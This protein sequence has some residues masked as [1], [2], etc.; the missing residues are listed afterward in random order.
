[1]FLLL[2]SLVLII[3][4]FKTV[5]N[6]MS[7]SLSKMLKTDVNYS[8][9]GYSYYVGSNYDCYGSVCTNIKNELEEK[10]DD[11]NFDANKVNNYFK[12]KGINNYYKYN[13]WKKNT[14]LFIKKYRTMTRKISS[15]SVN[16][17]LLTYKQT[18]N[19]PYYRMFLKV[20]RYICD[21]FMMVSILS[22]IYSI[23]FGFRTKELSFEVILIV[24]ILL[25]HLFGDANARYLLP[26]IVPLTIMLIVSI[27]NEFIFSKKVNN[28][29]CC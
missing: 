12:Q 20:L 24:T 15:E 18:K 8:E 1:M 21:G 19:F 27:K 14:K 17:L 13:H 26:L 16:N 29:K 22:V 23:Y 5:T 7:N 6:S 11:E 2:I 3:V 25:S 28:D 9:N 10:M 4:P